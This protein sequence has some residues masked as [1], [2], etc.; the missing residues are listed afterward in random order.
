MNWYFAWKDHLE[1]LPLSTS[2][3]KVIL[4]EG[5]SF[6]NWNTVLKIPTWYLILLKKPGIFGA[7]THFGDREMLNDGLRHGGIEGEPRRIFST[8]FKGFEILH[9]KFTV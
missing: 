4:H 9:C 1:S 2:D 5:K 7:G 8:H 6:Y 3:L